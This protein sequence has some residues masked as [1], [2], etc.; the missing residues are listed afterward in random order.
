MKLYS[1]ALTLWHKV[2]ERTPTEINGASRINQQQL[3]EISVGTCLGR[4]QEPHTTDCR[5]FSTGELIAVEPIVR[6]W[7]LRL[8]IPLECHRKLIGK[9]GINNDEIAR[10]F[11]LQTDSEG[12]DDESSVEH[13]LKCALKLDDF[14]EHNN[15]ESDQPEK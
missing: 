3:S 5:Y 12:Y 15:S 13:A 1:Y 10:L 4:K 8:L 14:D 7:I 11:A 6:L 2:L 9:H